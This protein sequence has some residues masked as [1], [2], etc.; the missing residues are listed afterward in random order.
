MLKNLCLT[1]F[2][3][4]QK[5]TLLTYFS[6]TKSFLILGLLVGQPPHK[7]TYPLTRNYYENISPRI[8]FC[9]NL[10]DLAPSNSAGKNDEN[11]SLRLIF[12]NSGGILRPQ[13]LQERK[14]FFKELRVKFVIKNSQVIILCQRIPCQVQPRG[15]SC[16]ET[17]RAASH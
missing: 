6:P 4:F 17:M 8:L 13:N 16:T 9:R 3:D 1:C 12:L 7:P 14:T 5:N 2:L 11:N 10:G 15:P